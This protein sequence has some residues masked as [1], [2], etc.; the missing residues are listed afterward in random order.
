MFIV[1]VT[2]FSNAHTHMPIYY[3]YMASA[4]SVRLVFDLT[5][6]WPHAFVQLADKWP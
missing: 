4:V 3:I 2:T 5:S 6:D 1:A